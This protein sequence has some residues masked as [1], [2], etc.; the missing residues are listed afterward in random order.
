MG[1]LKLYLVLKQ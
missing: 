1:H